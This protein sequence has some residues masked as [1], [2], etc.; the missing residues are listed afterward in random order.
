MY[1]GK[2]I[3]KNKGMI[4]MKVRTAFILERGEW[5]GYKEILR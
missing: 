3:K 4:T 1:S 5:T 2:T